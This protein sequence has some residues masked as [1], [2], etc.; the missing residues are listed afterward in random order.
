MILLMLGLIFS[1]WHF[2]AATDHLEQS[3]HAERQTIDTE[4]QLISASDDITDTKDHTSDTE[5]QIITRQAQQTDM[6]HDNLV[7][8]AFQSDSDHDCI[9]EVTRGVGAISTMMDNVSDITIDS[10]DIALIPVRLHTCSALSRLVSPAAY[11]KKP[12]M[13]MVPLF[14]N[15]INDFIQKILLHQVRISTHRQL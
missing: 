6:F 3:I 14:L 4:A 1:Q 11:C 7:V 8:C 5:A 15:K 10:F 13:F 9:N 2:A 12:T